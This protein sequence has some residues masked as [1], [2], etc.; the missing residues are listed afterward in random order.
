LAKNDRGNSALLQQTANHQTIIVVATLGE[1]QERQAP[2]AITSLSREP[3]A[4]YNRM[5]KLKRLQLFVLVSCTGI[6]LLEFFKDF[7]GLSKY[8]IVP[9][10]ETIYAVNEFR[11]N[12]KFNLTLKALDQTNVSRAWNKTS[13]LVK[14]TSSP[15]ARLTVENTTTTPVIRNEESIPKLP[16]KNVPKVIEMPGSKPASRDVQIETRIKSDGIFSVSS[17]SST[18]DLI[19]VEPPKNRDENSQP[20]SPITYLSVTEHPRPKDVEKADNAHLTL[21]NQT[22]R[23]DQRPEEALAKI[24]YN[25]STSEKPIPNEAP[26]KLFAKKKGAEEW[27]TEL[28]IPYLNASDLQASGHFRQLGDWIARAYTDQPPEVCSTKRTIKLPKASEYVFLKPEG[29]LYN[30]VP[31]SASSTLAGINN[32]IA[33]RQFWR[34]YGNSSS[35]AADTKACARMDGHIMGAGRFYGNRNKQ[36]S[37]L[38][39]SIRDPASRAVSRIFYYQISMAGRNATDDVVLHYL[40]NAYNPQSGTISKGKGGFTLS[41]L[42]LEPSLADNYAWTKSYPTIVQRPDV[43]HDRAQRIIEG[44]DFL[45]VTERMDES[46]VALQLL[47]GLRVGDILSSSSKVGGGYS[48]RNGKNGNDKCQPMKKSFRS[49]AVKEYLASDQWFAIN[50][51]DYVLHAA[52][53]RSLD[54]TIERL[55]K[56]RFEKALGSYKHAQSEVKERCD[57]RTHFPCSADGTLQSELA[58]RDCYNGDEG[59]G[60]RCIDEVAA[61]HGW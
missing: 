12:P 46:L 5:V 42:S 6:I 39:G 40:Q 23:Q 16:S 35:V 61:E 44:Y 22:S 2:S 7:R 18:S 41:Y 10:G 54:L 25:T 34:L 3:S 50:Y 29:L 43:L 17:T 9:A 8:S 37:F 11:F 33:R 13:L 27:S 28:K 31:K 47:L 21:I 24:I 57:K 26:K 49:P 1:A 30:K 45:V 20:N 52:A 32:R 58:K 56:Q 55:G 38:W 60:F 48:L 14:G 15:T 59:C 4:K 53:N 36:R 51:G 19:P